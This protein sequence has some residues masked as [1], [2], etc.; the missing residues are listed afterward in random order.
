MKRLVPA[1]AHAF[2]LAAARGAGA[3][4]EQ[5]QALARAILAAEA[6]GK[7]NVG[8]A[9]LPDYLDALRA[10]RIRGAAVPVLTSPAPALLQ[11]DAG[12][13]LAQLGFDLAFDDLADRARR[14][15]LA[16]FASRNSYTTG[17][18]GDYVLR[19]AEAGLV[20]FGATNGPALMAPPGARRALYCTNPFAFAAPALPGPPLLIDQASSATAYVN[21]RDAAA[22]GQSIPEGYAI[23]EAGEPTRDAAA[24]MRGALLTFGG[25]R[26]AN[27]ALMV[28]TLAAG[29]GGALW[30]LD[31]PGFT[32]GAASPGAGLTIVAV[33]AH[34]LDP[35][36][37]ARLGAQLARLAGEGAHIPGRRP[38]S[39]GDIE[40]DD[41]LFARIAAFVG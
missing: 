23:D 2:A 29:L 30:S 1:D 22:H 41:A 35:D 21:I 27:V 37:A 7:R 34:L 26:G 38:A 31:A 40:F 6:R 33:A 28:E 32:S 14:F 17:E 3:A 12:G 16:L 24:A 18:L 39:L 10:G 4:P 9:H 19:L 15:G 20:A 5:A 13:G 8:F 11:C 36:F 25:A